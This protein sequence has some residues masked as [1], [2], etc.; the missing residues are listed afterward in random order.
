MTGTYAHR[1]G[2]VNN[3]A[4]DPDPS[5]PTFP[6]LLQKAGYET[7]YIGKWHMEPKADPRPGFDYWL[8]F[9]AQGVYENPNLNENGREFQADGYITDILTDYAVSWL[10]RKRNKPF[11]MILAH[12]AVHS[13]FTPAPR[14]KDAFPNAE[15][16]E[17][18]SYKDTFEDKPEWMRRAFTS[19]V[20]RE[21]WI[22]GLEKPV[23]KK[24]ERG[25]WNPGEP[26]RLDYYRTILGI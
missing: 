9:K 6:L 21:R 1:H 25:A 4:N 26:R 15:I 7:A 12:K 24:I 5:C 11:C 10:K 18:A 17:P 19:G 14:H 16:P 2:V 3:E 20:R 8:S 23:P 22:E 13:P